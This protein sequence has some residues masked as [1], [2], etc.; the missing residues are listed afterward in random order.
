MMDYQFDR[1]EYEGIGW[2]FKYVAQFY[3]A[4]ILLALGN[5]QFEGM[6]KALNAAGKLPQ[7]SNEGSNS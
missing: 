6:N 2:N 5:R 7:N 1:L 3:S 4:G